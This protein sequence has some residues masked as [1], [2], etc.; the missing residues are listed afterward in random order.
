MKAL[1]EAKTADL[2]LSG[3]V[4]GVL[5]FVITTGT[6]VGRIISNNEA[7]PLGNKA[8]EVSSE[9][10]RKTAVSSFAEYDIT[11]YAAAPHHEATIY[12]IL[13]KMPVMKTEQDIDRYIQKKAMGSPVTGKMVID[14]AKEYGVDVHMMLALMQLDSHFGTTGLGAKT[15]NPGNV[16]TYGKKV[17]SYTS[18]GDGVRGVARWLSKKKKA[19]AQAHRPFCLYST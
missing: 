9:S 7:T 18:W 16:A 2:L 10:I 14:A 3:G 19:G 17:H 6:G 11:K 13:E 8:V 5:L 1:T 12:A 15:K 4:L